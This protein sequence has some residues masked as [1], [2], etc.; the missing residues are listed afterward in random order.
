MDTLPYFP[1]SHMGDN[2]KDLPFAFLDEVA[3]PNEVYS[4][5]KE[6]APHGANSFLKVLTHIQKD[7]LYVNGRVVPLN[8]YPHISIWGKYLGISTI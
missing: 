7:S 4:L 2:F 6:F 3:L 8:V 5:R 1:L